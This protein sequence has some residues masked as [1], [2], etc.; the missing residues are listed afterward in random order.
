MNH[1]LC[2]ILCVSQVNRAISHLDKTQQPYRILSE[3]PLY[4]EAFYLLLDIQ[5][6]Q[7]F[8]LTIYQIPI[9]FPVIS[10][11][12]KIIRPIAKSNF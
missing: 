4:Q 9:G 8:L 2:I 6:T 5:N 11:N 3:Q 1:I 7:L 12:Q 10:P